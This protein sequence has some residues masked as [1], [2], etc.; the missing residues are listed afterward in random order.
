MGTGGEAFV[1]ETVLIIENDRSAAEC[2]SFIFEQEGYRVLT[3]L[4]GVEGVRLAIGHTPS[5]VV[6]DILME[7]I[8]GFE[9]LQ[10]MRS[11]SELA[12]AIVIMAS[13]KS[14]RPDIERARE[15]GADDYL[16]KPFTPEDLLATVTYHRS[17]R[18]SSAM[19]VRFWG[20]RGSIATPGPQTAQY[21]GNTSCVE[22]RCGGDLLVF[23]AGTGI[24]PL[25]LA[26]AREF[27]GR[28]LT[29]HLFISHTHWD[30][31][32][33]FPFF[34]PAYRPNTT[35]HVYGAAGEGRPLAKLLRGLMDPDYFPVALGDL[36]AVIHVH[37]FRGEDF[38][39]NDTKVSAMYLNHPGMTLGYR[40]SHH[41]KVLVYATDNEPY[42]ATLA[43]SSAQVPAAQDF[44]RQLDEDFVKFVSSADLY[45]GEAQYTDDEYPGKIGWGHS[46]VSA[47]ASVALRA[48]AKSLALFHHDPMHS[49]EVVSDM[50]AT[51]ERL[52]AA[53]TGTL[54]CFAA[55]EGQTIEL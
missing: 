8:H 26:L 30:H 48:R 43:R 49:D 1:N 5:I 24:R 33:G 4:D 52:I 40:V 21:G 51:V 23:D 19:T 44:G 37:E 45:V 50:V 10:A 35:I 13:A 17:R 39:I 27:A 12:G 2:L 38:A 18:R 20:T 25:G 16:V 42:R 55:R 29:V 41:G 22:V 46:S 47:T 34:V 9:V 54:S 3:A 15:L 28:P 31:I 32:Q 36:T 6:C 53:E 7:P 14:Y 11:R